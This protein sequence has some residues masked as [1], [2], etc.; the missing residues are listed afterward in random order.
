LASFTEWCKENRNLRLRVFFP[1]LNLKLR[2]CYNYYGVVDNAHGLNEFY[3]KATG[4]L[5]KW[6][7]RRSQRR[8]F[9]WQ[10]FKDLLEHTSGCQGHG[11]CPSDGLRSRQ[12]S[13]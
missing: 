12:R 1:T 13:S 9:N 8:S 6:L 4:I 11:S 2:G 5:F 3:G 10:G 7:N